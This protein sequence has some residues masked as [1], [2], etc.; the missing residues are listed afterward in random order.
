MLCFLRVEERPFRAV[1]R[2]E[3]RGLQP[4]WQRKSVRCK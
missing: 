2:C 3:N 1:F 4:W